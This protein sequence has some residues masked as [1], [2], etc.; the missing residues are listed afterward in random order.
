MRFCLS[1]AADPDAARASSAV[2]VGRHAVGAYPVGATAVRFLLLAGNAIH[3]PQYLLDIYVSVIG[4][5]VFVRRVAAVA[6]SA[7]VFHVGIVIGEYV[8]TGDSSRDLGRRA[9][10]EDFIEELVHEFGLVEVPLRFALLIEICLEPCG[11]RNG[12]ANG[13]FEGAGVF[14]LDSEEVVEEREV[15]G[16]EVSFAL[17]DQDFSDVEKVAETGHQA[18]AHAF[19]QLADGPD[20][21]LQPVIFQCLRKTCKHNPE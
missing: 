11:E 10:L 16:R 12:I 20:V 9:A 21:G 7:R 4:P 14:G 1:R 19:I 15:V 5:G 17:D 18:L 2:A 6:A 13:L 8:F 3:P